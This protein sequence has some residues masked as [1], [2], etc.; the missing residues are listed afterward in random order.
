MPGKGID[1]QEILL[2]TGLSSYLYLIRLSQQWDKADNLFLNLP[3][4]GLCSLTKPSLLP[5]KDCPPFMG[6]YH[7]FLHA[8]CVAAVRAVE[9]LGGEHRT[10]QL[11]EAVAVT[12]QC[13]GAGWGHTSSPQHSLVLVLA[14]RLGAVCRHRCTSL[15]PRCE[16][17]VSW[18]KVKD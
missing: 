4:W 18:R 12:G 7:L 10:V 9:T 1:A 8:L 14:P 16:L 5:P 15:T 3:P 11:S 17:E 6:G 2:G 13:L